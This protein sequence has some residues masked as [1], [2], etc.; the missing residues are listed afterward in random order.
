ML[1][2]GGVPAAAVLALLPAGL[3]G[4]PVPP[5]PAF[6]HAAGR[7]LPGAWC[8]PPGGGSHRADA[9]AAGRGGRSMRRR[10]LPIGPGPAG[11]VHVHGAPTRTGLLFA[12]VH[13]DGAAL[14]VTPQLR[15]DFAADLAGWRACAAVLG[16][17]RHQDALRAQ[18]TALIGREPEATGGVLL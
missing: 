7:G 16:P 11:R 1:R 4:A 15:R 17:S 3:P 2:I 12:E 10:P 9:L 13:R 6:L 14:P 8:S 18:A 5:V